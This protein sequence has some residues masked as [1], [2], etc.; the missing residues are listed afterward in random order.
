M[1]PLVFRRGLSAGAALFLG[2]GSLA[3]PS[4]ASAES[5]EVCVCVCVLPVPV[6]DCSL[7]GGPCAV[8]QRCLR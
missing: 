5:S 7:H 4:V 2:L 1:P 3:L 6:P 8:D